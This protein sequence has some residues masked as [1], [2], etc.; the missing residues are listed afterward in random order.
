[1]LQRLIFALAHAHQAGRWSAT[2]PAKLCSARLT[3][4]RLPVSSS[5]APLANFMAHCSGFTEPSPAAAAMAPVPGLEAGMATHSST[6]ALS[7][8]LPNFLSN[9]YHPLCWKYLD[10]EGKNIKQVTE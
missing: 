10:I 3:R 2:A 8:F 9:K 4:G 1:M 5:M 6:I 7:F